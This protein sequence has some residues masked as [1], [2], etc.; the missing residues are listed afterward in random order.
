MIAYL[1]G[2]VLEK[3]DGTMLVLLAGDVGYAVTVPVSTYGMLPEPGEAVELRIYTKVS[4]DSIALYGFATAVEKKA[5]EKLIGVN[6]VGPALA[7]KVLSGMTVEHLVDSVRAGD[8]AGLTKVKG[9]GKKT[10]E[11][12]IMELRDKVEDLPGWGKA[13]VAAVGG[14]GRDFSPLERDVLSALI[15]LGSPAAAAE[16][17]VVKAKEVVKGA[18]FELLFRKSLELVR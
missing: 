16:E 14:M 10:A 7:V 15:N 11:R 4:E 13:G 2:T 6:G 8:V 18:D 9:L 12:L 17:A 5:F 1:R 3:M